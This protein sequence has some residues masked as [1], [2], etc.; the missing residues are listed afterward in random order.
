MIEVFTCYGDLRISASNNYNNLSDSKAN[1]N[2]IVLE[3][4]NYGGH[5]VINA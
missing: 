5:F 4:S 3:Q 1:L 2:E